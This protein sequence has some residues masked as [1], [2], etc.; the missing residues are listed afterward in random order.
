M[1]TNVARAS[2]L[3]NSAREKTVCSP[4]LR[5]LKRQ[6]RIFLELSGRAHKAVEMGM[7][8][9]K[10]T[11]T[12]WLEDGYPGAMGVHHLPD[13]TREVGPELEDWLAAQNDGTEEILALENEPPLTLA[14]L[15][16]LVSGQEVSQ[17]LQDIQA[18]WDPQHRASDV[19]GLHKLR[20]IIDAL[21]AEDE[22]WGGGR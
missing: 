11:L 22:G 6:M 19:I 2:A 1:D 21:L 7:G 17:L 13:W 5:R 8:L 18:G 9:S 10:G 4:K 15:L 16:A 20:Q 12:T 14:A 3:C